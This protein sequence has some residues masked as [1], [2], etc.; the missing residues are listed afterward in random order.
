MELREIMH[1]LKQWTLNKNGDSFLEMDDDFSLYVMIAETANNALP[2]EQINHRIFTEF[3]I[4][5][6]DIPKKSHIYTY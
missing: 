5:K 3:Q 6:S 2:K 1:L 4:K